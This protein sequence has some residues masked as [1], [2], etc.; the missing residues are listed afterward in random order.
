MISFGENPILTIDVQHVGDLLCQGLRA[1]VQ[2]RFTGEKI[3]VQGSID[4]WQLEILADA[5][6][7]VML[8]EQTMNLIEFIPEASELKVLY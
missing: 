2:D 7:K 4:E 3:A 1:H 5:L 6:M 8:E